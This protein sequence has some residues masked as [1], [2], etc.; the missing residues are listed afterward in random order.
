MN[1]LSEEEFVGY[2]AKEN[3]GKLT[4]VYQLVDARQANMA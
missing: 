1:F 2:M 3:S 4:S